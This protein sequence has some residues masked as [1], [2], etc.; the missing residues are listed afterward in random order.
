[1]VL[2]TG[3]PVTMPWAKNVEAII[4]S[5]YPGIGLDEAGDIESRQ[6]LSVS[7]AL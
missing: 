4:E 7:A 1:V 2:E 5:C 3:G 6:G